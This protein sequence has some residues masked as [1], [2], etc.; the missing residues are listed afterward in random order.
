[1]SQIR[2]LEEFYALLP[3]TGWYLAAG[4]MVR[5]ADGDHCC[6]MVFVARSLGHRIDN[7]ASSLRAAPAIGAE[8]W[9][10]VEIVDAADFDCA[11]H[12]D[13]LLKACNLKERNA[14]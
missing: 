7:P 12:R 13:A 14:K 11:P 5:R 9:I 3:D 4:R 2:T 1:M 8:E 6:P 10:R